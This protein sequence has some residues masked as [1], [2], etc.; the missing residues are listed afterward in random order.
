M[1]DPNRLGRVGDQR[2]SKAAARMVARRDL[3][4]RK[5]AMAKFWR[6]RLPEDISRPALA[7]DHR[8]QKV[9]RLFFGKRGMIESLDSERFA[10][11]R[12]SRKLLRQATGTAGPKFVV[13][14]V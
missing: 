1:R 7:K 4:I 11:R 8:R 10:F 6:Q 13:V 9:C 2:F 5:G 12:N 14:A 3:H